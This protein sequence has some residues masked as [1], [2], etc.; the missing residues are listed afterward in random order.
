MIHRLVLQILVVLT[1]TN[2]SAFAQPAEP[3]NPPFAYFKHAQTWQFSINNILMKDLMLVY[4]ND[5]SPVRYAEVTLS[6]RF[7]W[8][9]FG[10][11]MGPLIFDDPFWYQ[12][13]FQV[14]AGVKQYFKKNFYYAPVILVSYG[15][16]RNRT[17][18]DYIDRPNND[19]DLDATLNRSQ[20]SVGPVVKLGYSFKD[21]EM[22]I[23]DWYVG[24]GITYKQT[25][26]EVLSVWG[27]GMDGVQQMPYQTN[28]QKVVP[29]IYI[30][31]LLGIYK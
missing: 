24:I 11:Q 25:R 18:A 31:V 16:F 3:P 22:F 4:S 30:G 14:R 20:F 17:L 27:N 2:L 7:R 29:V 15:R 6:Y 26:D 1:A 9:Y 8:H 28:Q 23:A 21:P 19:M 10:N 5:I 13:R 12:G